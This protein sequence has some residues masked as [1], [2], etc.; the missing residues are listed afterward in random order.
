MTSDGPLTPG[1]QSWMGFVTY[2]H[3]EPMSPAPQEW[4]RCALCWQPAL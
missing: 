2:S 4:C 1:R 3:V